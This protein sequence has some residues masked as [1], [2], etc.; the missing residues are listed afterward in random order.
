[1]AKEFSI[2]GSGGALHFSAR[3]GDGHRKD[4][5]ANG[6]HRDQVH[7]CDAKEALQKN[8]ARHDEYEE[9]K[10]HLFSFPKALLLSGLRT[11]AF[12]G[13]R[14]SGSWSGV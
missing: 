4:D 14:G 2:V 8:H 10:H 6:S 11:D 12:L 1:M 5:V 7:R 13:A 9:D 3:L